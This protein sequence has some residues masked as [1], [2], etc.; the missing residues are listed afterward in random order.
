MVR[1]DGQLKF[2]RCAAAVV[3]VILA[4]CGMPAGA[5]ADAAGIA[6]AADETKPFVKEGTY[7][8]TV[9]MDA[10]SQI[11]D[12]FVYRDEYFA[13]DS[14]RTAARLAELSIQ[15]ALASV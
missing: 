13:S 11:E 9:T 2:R 8:F 10:T 14:M 7:H 12:T 1:R 6:G 5:F 3:A 15:T 4:F